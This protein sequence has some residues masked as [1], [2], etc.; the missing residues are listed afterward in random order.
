MITCDPS[1]YT[2][3]HPHLTVSSFMGNSIGLQRDKNISMERNSGFL[4]ISKV[5]IVCT[6]QIIFIF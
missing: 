5:N 6:S 1:I 2:M 3:D 4:N